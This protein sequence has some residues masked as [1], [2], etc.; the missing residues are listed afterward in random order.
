MEHAERKIET[1][2][3]ERFL[4]PPLE[5]PRRAYSLEPDMANGWKPKKANKTN[6]NNVFSINYEQVVV[7]EIVKELYKSKKK[8]KYYLVYLGK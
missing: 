4:D 8:A 5:L 6:I 2:E 7:D 1:K 3:K